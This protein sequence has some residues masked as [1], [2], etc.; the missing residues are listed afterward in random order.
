MVYGVAK[1]HPNQLTP[2]EPPKKLTKLTS[3][4]QSKNAKMQRKG[5]DLFSWRGK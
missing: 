2:G 4:L 3:T 1:E 5:A